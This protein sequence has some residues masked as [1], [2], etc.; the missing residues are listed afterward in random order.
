MNVPGT[1]LLKIRDKGRLVVKK[2]TRA[3]LA[4]DQTFI[5]TTVAS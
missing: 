1:R 4:R 3:I 2:K 5:A